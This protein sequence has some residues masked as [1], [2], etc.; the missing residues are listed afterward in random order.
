V[1]D[2]I[3]GSLGSQAVRFT[4]L[5]EEANRTAHALYGLG[6]RRAPG[7]VGKAAR[8]QSSFVITG[9][10]YRYFDDSRP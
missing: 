6:V 1:P 8:P 5:D 4:Q 10:C 9:G 3:A 2:A 7:C